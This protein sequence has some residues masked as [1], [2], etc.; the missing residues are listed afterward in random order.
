MEFSTIFPASTDVGDWPLFV[1]LLL[2]RFCL[3]FLGN[4]TPGLD[5]APM[6]LVPD[7][8]ASLAMPMISSSIPLT[9]LP[10]LIFPY[11]LS[12]DRP[13]PS[14]LPEESK[15]IV[16]VIPPSTPNTVSP[17]VPLGDGVLS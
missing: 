15:L 7:L 17:P 9:A 16:F 4:D 11:V 1:A 6:L 3:I 8:I 12:A 14:M 5:V 13:A 2:T 10:D